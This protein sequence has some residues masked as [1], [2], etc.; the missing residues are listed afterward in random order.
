MITVQGRFQLI[1]ID[2]HFLGQAG[3]RPQVEQ[4]RCAAINRKRNG[5]QK[6]FVCLNGVNSSRKLL[7]CPAEDEGAREG[8]G[9]PACAHGH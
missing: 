6:L 8:H 7:T 2:D 4:C 3:L 9:L 5:F 1:R